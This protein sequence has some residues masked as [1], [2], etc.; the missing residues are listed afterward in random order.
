MFLSFEGIDGSGKQRGKV[1]LRIEGMPVEEDR[2]DFIR[3]ASAMAT[4]ALAKGAAND[5]KLT[6]AIRLAVRR[7]ATAWTGKKPVVEVLI[8]RV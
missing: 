5:E 2:E 6:E 3:D 7:C 1:Q 8:V 4:A